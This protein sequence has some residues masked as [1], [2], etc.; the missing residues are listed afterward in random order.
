MHFEWA[1]SN[2]GPRTEDRRRFC[3]P[4]PEA[5]LHVSSRRVRKRVYIAH[6]GG[7][8]GM[9]RTRNGYGPQRGYLQQQMESMPELQHPSIPE[10]TIHDYDPL[11]DSSNM[12]PVE[13]VKIA[14]DIA[15]H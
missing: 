8:I 13:W 2:R 10:F 15:E 4:R 11:L 6:T 5:L 3:V 1:F 14:R 12:T 9:N 7:T